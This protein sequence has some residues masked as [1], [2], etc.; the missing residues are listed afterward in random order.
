[1]KY[2]KFKLIMETLEPPTKFIE[3]EEVSGREVYS[4]VDLS[5]NSIIGD[6]YIDA[7]GKKVYTSLGTSISKSDE[8][9]TII[10][11]DGDR[12]V[13]V[14]AKS[15]KKGERLLAPYEKDEE[16]LPIPL[17]LSADSNI[18]QV[19]SDLEN[20]QVIV[21]PATPVKLGSIY[22]APWGEKVKIVSTDPPRIDKYRKP[23]LVKE[24]PLNV[25]KT[26]TG[27][28][29]LPTSGTI[30]EIE[31]CL[32][33]WKLMSA[34]M[35]EASDRKSVSEFGETNLEHLETLKRGV[36]AEC[37]KWHAQ[38]NGLDLILEQ[39]LTFFDLRNLIILLLRKVKK[40]STKEVL[41]DLMQALVTY[42]ARPIPLQN[43]KKMVAVSPPVFKRIY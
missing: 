5:P 3:T 18:E 16:P 24:D 17:D 15:I 10:K 40:A 28:E 33:N 6:L 26:E 21:S 35:Q 36:L 20:G 27:I 31:A 42:E 37:I 25:W 32:D 39:E 23:V 12:G 2:S 11:K 14:A 8:S 38:D 29:L 43:L 30:E 22:L 34:E 41:N 4:T 1:M 9:N 7:D 19:K 13:L